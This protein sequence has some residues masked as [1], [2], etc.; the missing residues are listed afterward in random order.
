MLVERDRAN[1]EPAFHFLPK[2]ERWHKSVCR[3]PRSPGY[4][5]ETLFR[6]CVH[7]MTNKWRSYDDALSPSR[8]ST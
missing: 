6:K 5:S 3:Q 2:L 8:N 1:S 4:E 7:W